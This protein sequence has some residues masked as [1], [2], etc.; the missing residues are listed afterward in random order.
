M[1][2]CTWYLQRPV[3]DTATYLTLSYWQTPWSHVLPPHGFV[4]Q[5]VVRI[6]RL[7]RV[8]L[9]ESKTMESWIPYALQGINLGKNLNNQFWRM[10]REGKSASYRR[11]AASKKRET[12]FLS[13]W[14]HWVNMWLQTP[15]Q[16]SED[17]EKGQRIGKLME[18]M[19][20]VCPTSDPLVIWNINS[21]YFYDTELRTNTFL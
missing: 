13:L 17:H 6:P 2:L 14:H 8:G 18:G 12:V 21:P 5:E 16:P 3:A 7:Q 10:R 1:F 4:F 20:M 19:L 15:L 9:N 11:I